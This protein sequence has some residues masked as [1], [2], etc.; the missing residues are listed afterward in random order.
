[1]A[2]TTNSIDLRRTVVSTSERGRH[3]GLTIGFTIFSLAI[4]LG[5]FIEGMKADFSSLAGDQINILLIC[6]KKDYPQLF[7]GDQVIGDER[8]VDYYIP[9][10]VGLVRLLSGPDHNYLR[11]LNILLLLTSLI[12]MLGWWLLFSVWGDRWTAAILAFL[13]RGIMYPPGFELWGVAGL[14]TALPRTLFTA[15]LAFV[16][17][18]WLRGRHSQRGWLLACLLC[19]LLVNLHPLSGVCIAISLLLAETAWTIS[20][21]KGLK[22]AVYRATLG[23]ALIFVGMAPSIWTYVSK[24]GSAEG[25]NAIEFEQALRLRIGPFFWDPA[26]YVALWLRPKWAILVLLPWVICLLVP[27]RAL[28]PFKNAIIALG[29]FFV[30]SVLAAL[31]PFVIES[32]LKDMG[33]QARFA[34]QMVRSGKYVIIPTILLAGLLLTLGVKWLARSLKV[35]QPTVAAG[36][37][38]LVLGLTVVARHPVFDRVPILGDDVVRYLWPG[39]AQAPQQTNMQNL[40]QW[41]RENTP[42]DSQF[43]GPREISPAALRP[44]VHDW[45]SAVF[46]IEGNPAAFVEA[47]KRERMLRSSEYDNP[48]LRTK[49]F[50]DWG[51]DYL[52]TRA[53]L[54]HLRQAYSDS[55]WYVY[56]LTKPGG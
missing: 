37:I 33:Y 36:L 23:G 51:A 47:A 20:E 30:G 16:L 41:I 32:I 39:G 26:S 7:T 2:E 34:F 42:E 12:H 27:R 49:L 22:V 38:C 18:A 54:P 40:F 50:A 6:A 31:M 13:T 43:M 55:G 10:F 8:N 25:V 15:V 44:V 17:W 29:A 48:Q 56:D 46:L 3:V 4:S 52:V 9:V 53:L 21:S 28:A 19:G 1:M 35:A 24:L 5:F 14:W 45:K 11:G